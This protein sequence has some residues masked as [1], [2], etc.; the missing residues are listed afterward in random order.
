LAPI[1]TVT[2]V[3][4]VTNTA[5]MAATAIATAG[6]LLVMAIAATSVLSPISIDDAPIVLGMLHQVFR[7]N[8]VTSAGG[9]AGHGDVFFM[10]LPDIA[11]NTAI[12]ADTV[13]G[14]V[15][16]GDLAPMVVVIVI[17]LITIAALVAGTA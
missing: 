9:I 5:I 4:T 15:A 13:D 10:H 12:G 14:L 8:P 2:P 1:T 6:L 17:A 11:T 7:L 16:Q 3:N